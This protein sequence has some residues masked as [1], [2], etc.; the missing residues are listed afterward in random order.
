MIIHSTSDILFSYTI[1]FIYSFLFLF[2]SLFFSLPLR[3]SATIDEV[4]QPNPQNQPSNHEINLAQPKISTTKSE[5]TKIKR[6]QQ[7]STQNH[8]THHLATDHQTH[9]WKP[10]NHCHRTWS[11]TRE[12]ANRDEREL[13]KNWLFYLFILAF[14]TFITGVRSITRNK[15]SSYFAISYDST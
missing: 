1:K 4:Q 8:W 9:H 15:L 2:P 6:A 14:G 5:Q 11:T 10:T 13:I 3:L 12:R 7:K